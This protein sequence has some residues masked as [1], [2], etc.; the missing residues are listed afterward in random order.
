VK[1]QCHPE[2]IEGWLKHLRNPKN[3]IVRLRL[4]LSLTF[5]FLIFFRLNLIYP[6]TKVSYSMSSWACRRVEMWQ[7]LNVTLSLSKCDNW[8][9]KKFWS[10]LSLVFPLRQ[11]Q[12]KLSTCSRQAN[13]AFH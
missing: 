6:E 10:V 3:F 11:A 12:D 4:S 7:F 13:S 9:L 2:L 1:S 5:S 8:T